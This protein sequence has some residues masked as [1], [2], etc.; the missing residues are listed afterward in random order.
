MRLT[1][2]TDLMNDL[3]KQTWFNLTEA[4]RLKMRMGEVTVTELN[5]LAI[6]RLIDRKHLRAR[7]VATRSDEKTTGTDFEIWVKLR[8]GRV[9]GFA[10][11]AKIVYVHNGK[12]EYRSLGHGNKHGNQMQLLEDHAARRGAQPVHLFFNGWDK[13]DP[14]APKTPS[15]KTA[16]L[17]GCA[18]VMT[19]VVLSVRRGIGKRNGVNRVAPYLDVSI[20]WSELFLVPDVPADTS[21][22]DGGGSSGGGHDDGPTRENDQPPA[23]G[24]DEP[25][26]DPSTPPERAIPLRPIESTEADIA[27][28]ESRLSRLRGEE[29][30]PRRATQLPSYITR[31]LGVARDQVEDDDENYDAPPFALLIEEQEV[32]AS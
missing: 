28:L 22:D 32:E 26:G 2:L 31:S 30:Q 20:P 7:L 29:S 4:R 24:G 3:S 8:S 12:Y 15:G 5:L 23:A 6:A 1:Q 18:A 19:P 27:A 9:I 21:S 16:E 14:K 11:Q 10:V 13:S 25:G 17:Y